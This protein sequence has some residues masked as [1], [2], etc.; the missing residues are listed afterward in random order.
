MTIVTIPTELKNKPGVLEIYYKFNSSIVAS[1]FV[2]LPKICFGI[3][4]YIVFQTISA[5]F[6]IDE[7]KGNQNHTSSFWIQNN[8]QYEFFKIVF[9]GSQVNFPG[10]EVNNIFNKLGVSFFTL[11]FSS[12]IYDT[13]GNNLKNYFKLLSSCRMVPV[14]NTGKTIESFFPPSST[15]GSAI[16]AHKHTSKKEISDDTSF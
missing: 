5:L 3:N 11:D 9:H 16:L 13:L 2:M 1:S 8:S 15:L 10:E 4:T 6:L 7:D 12:E 14:L